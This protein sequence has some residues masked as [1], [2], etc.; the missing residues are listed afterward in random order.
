M[1]AFAERVRKVV[2]SIPK[3]ETLSYGEVARR[4]GNPGAARAVGMVMKRNTDPRVPCHRV[5]QADGSL[6]GYNGLQGKKE[7]LLK[8]EGAL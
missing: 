3:G 1:S 5:I 6:G 2:S 7:V 4:A 8:E